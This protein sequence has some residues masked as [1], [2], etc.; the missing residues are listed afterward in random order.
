LK[1]LF[2]KFIK[3]AY[4]FK[5]LVP[6]HYYQLQAHVSVKFNVGDEFS[7]KVEVC[8][9]DVAD[10]ASKWL[11]VSSP[12]GTEE[13]PLFRW[14]IEEPIIVV[15]DTSIPPPNKKLAEIHEKYGRSYKAFW[16]DSSFEKYITGQSRK[17]ESNDIKDTGEIKLEDKVAMAPVK[18]AVNMDVDEIIAVLEDKS[19]S[20]DTIMSD[21]L[22]YRWLKI[23]AGLAFDEEK[24]ARCST[25]VGYPQEAISCMDKQ[26][27]CS[28]F[29]VGYEAWKGRLDGPKCWRPQPFDSDS[30]LKIDFTKTVVVNG[31]ML[32][33]WQD[34]RKTPEGAASP[35]M[36]VTKFRL[37]YSDNGCTWHC[38]QNREM[39]INNAKNKL[40]VSTAK[41]QKDHK[42]TFAVL[43][44]ILARFVRIRPVDCTINIAIRCEFFL[45]QN[46]QVPNIY[47]RV[48]M[49]AA[50]QVS[51]KDHEQL[52]EILKDQ[53]PNTKVF[54]YDLPGIIEQE[55]QN[56]T[57][58]TNYSVLDSMLRKTV[59]INISC[60]REL[61]GL[62]HELCQQ[63][64]IGERF[65]SLSVLS[66]D[67]RKS[68]KEM[69][70]EDFAGRMK[71]IT[72]IV[73]E[74]VKAGSQLTFDY[75][76]YLVAACMIAGGGL[77]VNS[78]VAVVAS[79]LVSPIM[80]PVLAICFGTVIKNKELVIQGVY[81]EAVSLVVCFIVGFA[82]GICFSATSLYET[83]EW[84]TSEMRGRGRAIVLFEGVLIALPS[85]VGVAVSVLGGNM[86]SLVGVAM[87]A[88]LLPPAVNFG[89][90]L[91]IK[92]F[93]RNDDAVA[94][95]FISLGLALENIMI[96]YFVAVLVFWMK[97][98]IPAKA[99]LW[100]FWKAMEH[101]VPQNED[102][103]VMDASVRDYKDV[104]SLKF[105][106]KDN[107]REDGSVPRSFINNY[108]ERSSTHRSLMDIQEQFDQNKQTVTPESTL[109]PRRTNLRATQ[110]SAAPCAA[111][112][113]ARTLLKK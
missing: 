26:M 15:S 85:G 108:Y 14:M 25:T 19:C 88:S 109:G 13:N 100:T 47:P 104:K 71:E 1:K 61:S 58:L 97:E 24:K 75:Y 22:R 9:G 18:R 5:I 36:L 12:P 112:W 10:V 55:L 69:E 106:S 46:P 16:N 98:V 50:S 101:A 87:S 81:A 96:I 43:P 67:Y 83:Y 86:A 23:P 91:A 4:L 2:Q 113:K 11:L 107:Y 72:D 62:L 30:F 53:H 59:E 27:T 38:H 42:Y 110:L 73:I 68:S 51:F 21:V 34:P 41:M 8:E 56:S 6:K 45:C 74:N 79:M 103:D 37:D 90:M 54:Q 77:A 82:F 33:G 102:N 89:M 39:C 105:A 48:V 93:D 66:I 40:P 80:G 44:P 99:E 65:G 32:Q 70:F 17:S 20:R 84:P 31:L 95:A 35:T 3:M 52:H 78:I 63:L 29:L 64:Q 7:Q 60:P 111:H 28:S 94:M 57:Q 76:S 92:I 49:L